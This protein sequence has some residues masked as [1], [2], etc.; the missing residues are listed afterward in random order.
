MN[1]TPSAARRSR[2]RRPAAPGPVHEAGLPLQLTGLHRRAARRPT[3]RRRL[4]D[5]RPRECRGLVRR[6]STSAFRR[7]G[8]RPGSPAAARRDADRARFVDD[9]PGLGEGGLGRRPAA[10]AAVDLTTPGVVAEPEDGRRP[11]ERPDPDR[12]P[13]VVP[14]DGLLGLPV[15]VPD[16]ARIRHQPLRAQPLRQ[17]PEPAERARTARAFSAGVAGGHGG[18]GPGIVGWFHYDEPDGANVSARLAAGRA[19]RRRRACRS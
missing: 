4:A 13:A 10:Q 7:S 5:D 8:P 18:S 16:R 3:A 15:G 6:S 11:A 9:L 17:P 2:R 19:A 14:D 12:R 1:A